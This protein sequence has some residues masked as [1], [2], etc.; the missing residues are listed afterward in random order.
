MGGT[1]SDTY[2]VNSATDTITEYSNQ[3]IDWIESSVSYTLGDNL[4][5][6]ELTSGNTTG[7]GN[8]L[9][10]Y[11]YADAGTNTLHGGGGNDDIFAGADNDRLYGNLGHDSLFGTLGSDYL[12]GGR[13]N[14]YLGGDYWDISGDSNND[15]LIGGLG[16][17]IL[18][19]G[20]GSDTLTGGIGADSFT[21]HRPSE[22]AVDSITDFV[23]ADDTINVY[24][25][26]DPFYDQYFGG[27]LTSGAPITADQLKIGSAAAD[28]SD[29]FIYNQN[30]G[31]LYFD[32]DGTG[33]AE[34]VQFA[35]LSAGL[36]I[37]NADISVI[38]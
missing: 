29:R 8:A 7:R 5:N 27:G 18:V 9:D 32:V 11:L 2:T 14:D 4:E 19:G 22:D 33:T 6:L 16:N 1:G 38:G 26:N 24:A 30:T 13:G 3:G 28:A 12:N 35:W 34:Q 23:V 37:T 17:D 20:Y 31:A 25:P 21:F 10:N 15:T 36:G